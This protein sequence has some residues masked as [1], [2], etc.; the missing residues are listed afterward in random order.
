M[1]KTS[2][3]LLLYRRRGGALEVLV[4]HPGGPLWAKKDA[5][6]WSLPKGLLEDGEDPEAAARRE[7]REE[8]GHDAPA[9]P[10]LALGEVK[11]KSGKRVHG[12]AV[13]GELD[14][15]ALEPGTFEMAWPPRSGKKATF[16]EIDRVAWLAPDAAKDKLNPAQ[17]DF[18]DRLLAALEETS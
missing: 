14:P 4:A 5:G 6:C 1:A 18:V 9:G 17:A 16:P 3:G 7:F 2:A 15:A 13:E 8:T 12:F 10:Y 11:L